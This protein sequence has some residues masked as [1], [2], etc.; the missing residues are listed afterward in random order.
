MTCRTTETCSYPSENTNNL[1]GNG[2]NR[3]NYTENPFAACYLHSRWSRSVVTFLRR[4]HVRNEIVK[5]RLRNTLRKIVDIGRHI[6][7]EFVE[8]NSFAIALDRKTPARHEQ[9]P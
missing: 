6:C 7:Q 5:C 9:L 2:W 8:G 1:F 4:S 3:P